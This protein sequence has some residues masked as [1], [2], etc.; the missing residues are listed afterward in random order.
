M[1]KY[2]VILT[3]RRFSKHSITLTMVVI[4]VDEKDPE[5]TTCCFF[6]DLDTLLHLNGQK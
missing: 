2:N 5:N 3:S 6:E 4:R 1:F